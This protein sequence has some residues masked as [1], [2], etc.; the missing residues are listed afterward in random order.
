MR[1]LYVIENITL[2]YGYVDRLENAIHDTL[3]NLD[4]SSK[5]DQLVV[6]SLRFAK[7]YIS[8][9]A[10]NLEVEAEINFEKDPTILRRQI[11]KAMDLNKKYLITKQY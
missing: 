1:S 10:F 11:T 2:K 6:S 7:H 9:L 4:S 3:G 5:L 8:I